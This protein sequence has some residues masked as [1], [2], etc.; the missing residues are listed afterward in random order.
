MKANSAT[1]VV[2]YLYRYHSN[3]SIVSFTLNVPYVGILIIV[4]TGL[5]TRD[6]VS[7]IQQIICKFSFIAKSLYDIYSVIQFHYSCSQSRRV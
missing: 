4:C 2:L 6:G 5:R 1:V 3:F 7:Y